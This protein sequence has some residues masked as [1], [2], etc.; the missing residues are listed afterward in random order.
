MT[1]IPRPYVD[2]HGHRYTETIYRNWHT[3]VIESLGIRKANRT[4]EDVLDDKGAKARARL[5]Q[6]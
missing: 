3:R 1:V 2:R 4:K 5:R 6:S